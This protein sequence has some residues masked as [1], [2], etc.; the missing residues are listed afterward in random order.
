LL[1]SPNGMAHFPGCPHKS[2]DPGYG[3]CAEFD[4]PRAWERLGN[5]EHVQAAGKITWT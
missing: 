3:R 4:T 5:R 2:D 1:I